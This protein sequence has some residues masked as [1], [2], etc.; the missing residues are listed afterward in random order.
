MAYPG[1]DGAHSAAACDRLFL[2]AEAWRRPELHPRSWRRRRAACPFRGPSDRELAH[3][4]RRRDTRLALRLVAL[5]HRR[6]RACHP[7]LPRRR[8]GRTLEAIRVVCRI[9]PRSTS[10]AACWR[11]CRGR[12]RSRPRRRPTPPTRSPTARTP[13]RGRYRERA[14]RAD[15]RSRRSRRRRGRPPGGVYALRLG[16]PVTGS[17]ARR[18]SGGRPSRSSPTTSRAPSTGRSNR[19]GDTASTSFS[20]SRARSRQRR[21]ATARRRPRRASA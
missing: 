12:R 9:P 14:R 17:T 4:P 20:S 13:S 21:G 3:R 2:H 10:A 7:P 11:A 18:A 1:R 6:D 16:R 15:V 19:S 5:D 8:R